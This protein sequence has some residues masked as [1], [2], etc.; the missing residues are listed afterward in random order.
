MSLLLSFYGDDFTGSTDAME[1]LAT[2]G[3][4]TV[5]FTR[6]P[7]ESQRS[8]FAD[9][10]AVG[11]AGISRSQSPQWMDG[12]LPT[13]FEW[14]KKQG[15]D[16]CHYKVCSTFDSSPEFGNI[17]RATE[18]GARIFGQ[19]HIP[20]IIGTPQ[21]KRFTLA[22]NLFAA[23]QGKTYRI[24]RHPVMSK[25]PVTPM[26]EADMRLHL[27]EQTS[28]PVHL[29]SNGEEGEGILLYDVHDAATQVAA[30]QWLLN[31]PKN[32]RPFVIGASGV[33]YALVRELTAQKRIPG[34]ASFDPLPKVSRVAAVSGSVSPTTERQ[35]RCALENGYIGISVN[36]VHLANEN[37]SRTIDATVTAAMAELNKDRSVLIYTA[38]GHTTDIGAQIDSI[39]EGRSKVG[40]S[41]GLIL[42]Q[43]ITRGKL[44]RA[45]ISGGDTSGHALAQLG[46][47]ALTTRFPL[48]QTPG[49]P[50]CNAYS[51][52]AQFNGIEI[53]M[54][55]GQIGGEDYF[56]K[57]RDGIT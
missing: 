3:V 9:R 20:L 17:G 10:Q 54:K 6:I 13:I 35:I 19:S 39:P 15:A 51:T 14:L 46:I 7:T 36:P 47:H 52:S 30:G 18:I 8:Q 2:H 55:G 43:L 56:V 11:I 28:I 25:H 53:A 50:L 21:L 48:T 45:I 24:D 38:L 49:S 37:R 16:F 32:A 12:H 42:S 5:L 44:R 26:R 41:L 22:G 40:E 27:A 57:L 31:A 23:F 1:A 29:V 4:S 34:K 33:E